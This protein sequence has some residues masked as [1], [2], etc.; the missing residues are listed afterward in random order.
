MSF[1]IAIVAL[2]G[3]LCVVNMVLTLGVVRRLREHTKLL[4]VLYETIDLMGGPPAAGRDLGVGD[5]AGDFEVTTADG[6]RLTRDSLPEGTVLAFM[7]PDCGGCH[8]K[9]PAFV[10]WAAGQDRSRVLAVV[11][12]RSGDSA[13]MIAT[14]RPVAQVVV[15][16]AVSA[17]F[18]VRSYP[19]FLEVAAGGTLL[20]AAPEISRLP[21]GAPA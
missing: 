17:A 1:L 15:D 7:S 16:G 13:D 4:D 3:A 5:V 12:N 19:T 8:E 9:L 21:A 10:S 14:L 18:R 6:D 20:A 2:V 11:D